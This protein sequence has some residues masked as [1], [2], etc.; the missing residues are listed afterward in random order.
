MVLAAE[1]D[2]GCFDGGV[3]FAE[4]DGMDTWKG[5][6]LGGAMGECGSVE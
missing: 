2:V 6:G 5:D 3:C 4:N 1:E